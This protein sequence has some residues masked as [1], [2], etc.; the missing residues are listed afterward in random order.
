VERL[1]DCDAAKVTAAQHFIEQNLASNA[2]VR[3]FLGRWGLGG[4]LASET[5]IGMLSGGQKVL[6]QYGVTL[7]QADGAAGPLRARSP[8][9]STP[10]STVIPTLLGSYDELMKDVGCWTKLRLISIR[11]P[12]AP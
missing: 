12:S 3:A 1:S 10:S 9:P 7:E 11:S 4:K 2:E 5:P 8:T 6:L